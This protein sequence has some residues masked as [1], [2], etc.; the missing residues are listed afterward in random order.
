MKLTIQE[1]E[2][3]AKLP[4]NPAF[5][6]LLG[7]LETT[8]EELALKMDGAHDDKSA[9]FAMSTWRAL[10]MVLKTLRH[11]PQIF[12]TTIEDYLKD[13]LDQMGGEYFDPAIVPSEKR[14]PFQDPFAD[15]DV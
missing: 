13:K 7:L 15:L 8:E 3:I 14:F 4:E 2:I 12:E 5:V 11:Q 1:R 6:L 9:L 10:R